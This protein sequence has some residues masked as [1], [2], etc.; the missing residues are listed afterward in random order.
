MPEGTELQTGG[1]AMLRL[2]IMARTVADNLKHQ[3]DKNTVLECHKWLTTFT[4]EQDY[5]SDESV[6]CN[7]GVCKW[8]ECNTIAYSV[9]HPGPLLNKLCPKPPPPNEG[10]WLS[11][12]LPNIEKPEIKS[13]RQASQFN[14]CTVFCTNI[15]ASDSLVSAS[16]TCICDYSS[17]LM[18]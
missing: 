17:I 18:L 8:T 13:A 6:I 11:K 2:C 4:T 14:H 5:T 16:Q 15:T 12:S 10:K 9:T 3:F 7:T 1:A